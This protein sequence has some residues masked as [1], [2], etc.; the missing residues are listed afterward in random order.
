[1]SSAFKD[2]LETTHFGSVGRKPA[3][4]SDAD[5][6]DPDDDEMEVSPPDVVAMLGFDPKEFSG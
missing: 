2:F 6:L 1:M 3:P 5:D 4:I